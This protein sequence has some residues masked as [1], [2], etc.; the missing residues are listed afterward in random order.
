MTGGT[1][2][3]I[4]LRYCAYTCFALAVIFLILTITL[5]F[6]MRIRNIIY[7]LS[8]KAKTEST[9]K[10]KEGYAVTGTLR[11]SGEVGIPTENHTKDNDQSQG[12]INTDQLNGKKRSTSQKLRKQP[13]Q[14]APSGADETSVLRNP[15]MGASPQSAAGMGGNFVIKK[16]VM[17][18]HTEERIS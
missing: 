15:N 6:R 14:P 8:G 1:Q 12:L 5:F 7:E 18:I 17:L 2:T 3:A 4:V 11:N 9:Q 10:M 13:N 16:D